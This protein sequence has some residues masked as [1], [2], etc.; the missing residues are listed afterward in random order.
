MVIVRI[1]SILSYDRTIHFGVP[2]TQKSVLKK[3]TVCLC[4]S[5]VYKPLNL[6]IQFKL[7][8]NLYFILKYI[9]YS[10]RKFWLCKLQPCLKYFIAVVSIYKFFRHSLTT[11]LTHR[12]TYQIQ[13]Q[14]LKFPF[15]SQSCSNLS[16]RFC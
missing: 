16:V 7:T 11:F 5:L 2:W 12:Q 4:L 8:A 14:P 13:I 9:V 3:M 6:F 1:K 15:I 10:H